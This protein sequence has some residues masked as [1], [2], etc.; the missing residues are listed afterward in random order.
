MKG[1]GRNVD[2]T[3]QIDSV[4]GSD[5]LL[6]SNVKQG[7]NYW[8][9]EPDPLRELQL[10]AVFPV[11]QIITGQGIKQGT[12]YVEGAININVEKLLGV[13]DTEIDHYTIFAKIQD[14]IEEDVK[15]IVDGNEISRQ[16]IEGTAYPYPKHTP[17]PAPG[18]APDP[19]IDNKSSFDPLPPITPTPT[20]FPELVPTPTSAPDSIIDGSVPPDPLIPTPT[21]IPEPFPTPTPDVFI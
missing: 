20:P 19:T 14:K 8:Q 11:A 3:V 1:Q 21:P 5:E 13:P 7:L 18:P 16:P 10:D 6:P 17:K 2:L 15:T 9:Y 4:G 12:P